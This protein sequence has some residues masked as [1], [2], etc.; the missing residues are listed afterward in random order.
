MNIL[1]L[2]V[3][4]L[5]SLAFA[6][7]SVTGTSGTLTHGATVT[8][9][10]SGFGT[11]GAAA[12]T[13]FGDMENNSVNARIGSWTDPDGYPNGSVAVSDNNQRHANSNYN[14][15]CTFSVSNTHCAFEGAPASAS[16]YAQYWLYLDSA[17]D[18][19]NANIKL[20]R[21]RAT[22]GAENLRVQS[23]NRGDVVV[24]GVDEGHGGYYSGACPPSPSGGWYPV[25]PGGS[26]A[27]AVWGHSSNCSDWLPGSIEWRSL[28]TDISKSAWHLFQ[29]EFQEGDASTANGVM[30]WWV[31]G[32]KVFDHSDI[33]TR[34]G[35]YNKYVQ[36]LGFYRDSLSDGSGTLHLDDLYIDNTWSRVEIGNAATYAASTHREIQ[37]AT[38]WDANGQSIAVTLNRGS[39]GAFDNAYLYVVDSTGAVN[40]DGYAITFGDTGADT[41]PAAFS[42]TDQTGVALGSTNNSDNVTITGIDNTTT[43]TLTGDASCKYSING[44]AWATANDNVSLNDNVALQNVASSSYSTAV[45]CT[46]NL[47]GVTDVWSRTTLAPANDPVLPRFQGASMSGGWR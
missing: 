10:G 2:I 18:W 30:R 20:F 15:A 14:A 32:R 41:T 3:L 12:P 26:T 35:S 4:L 11:K 19:G 39:F 47:G 28:Q 16:I 6:A 29:F 8:I 1:I 9:T 33:T 17:F 5:P 24:E 44:A 31:D 25:V 37:P 42:F 45:S 40:A 43:L 46:L 23:Y 34:T 21:L 36:D 22:S 13:A 7:P 38:A 27:D